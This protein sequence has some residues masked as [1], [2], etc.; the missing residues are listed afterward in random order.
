MAQKA[1]SLLQRYIIAYKVEKSQA[2]LDFI[3]ERYD[4]AKEE[5]E[6]QQV[7]FAKLSDQYKDLTSRVPQVELQ[8]VQTRMT[9]ANSVYQQLASQLEQAKIQVKKDTPVFTIVEPVTVPTERSKPSRA[10]ILVIWVFLGGV[11]GC[12]V[13][14]GKTAL[15]SV[16]KN[17]TRLDAFFY[18]ML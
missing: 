12:G 16:K 13:V 9:I 17:G 7:A 15:S 10:K 11:V 6:E 3:Q 2:E 14:Y 5:A 1:Q 4:A 18:S 8:K